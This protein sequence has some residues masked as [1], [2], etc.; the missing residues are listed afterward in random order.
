[1]TYID[2]L[3]ESSEITNFNEAPN[4]DPHSSVLHSQKHISSPTRMTTVATPSSS[5]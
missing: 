3:V 4:K 2:S 1:M 5:S